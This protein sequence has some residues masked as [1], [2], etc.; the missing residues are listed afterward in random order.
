M[1]CTHNEK[2]NVGGNTERVREESHTEIHR[3][4][5]FSRTSSHHHFLAICYHVRRKEQQVKKRLP[6][7]NQMHGS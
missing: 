3:V 6:Q 5:Y 7:H 2:E 4:D 1:Q